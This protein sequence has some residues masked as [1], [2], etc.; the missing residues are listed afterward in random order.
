VT[1]RSLLAAL[2]VLGL[3]VACG[4]VQYLTTVTGDAS[5]EIAA[6][7]AAGADKYAPYEWTAA[8]EYYHKAREEEGYADHQ[9]AV[10]FGNLARDLA[11]QARQIALAQAAA[12]TP[13][14]S[15]GTAPPAD[16]ENE[17]PLPQ[18]APAK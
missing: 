2:V 17:N 3:G 1:L 15:L 11:K 10:H 6:A 12:G 7:R 14:P 18:K 8:N 9:A 16:S 4:P 5:S 13:P